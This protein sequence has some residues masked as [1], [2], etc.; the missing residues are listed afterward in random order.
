M[1][2]SLKTIDTIISHQEGTVLGKSAPGSRSIA[3]VRVLTQRLTQLSNPKRPCESL[4]HA[5]DTLRRHR[6]KF[7]RVY[8]NSDGGVLY[9]FNLGDDLNVAYWLPGRA[10]VFNATADWLP[11][12]DDTPLHLR[13]SIKTNS[14]K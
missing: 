10:V 1:Q 6:V 12:V 3:A 7:D 14:A 11:C 5:E 4:A 9:Y 2:R 13:L 8:K